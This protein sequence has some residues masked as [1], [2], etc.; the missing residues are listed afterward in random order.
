MIYLYAKN[1]NYSKLANGHVLYGKGGVPNFPVRLANEIFRRCLSYSVKKE[2]ISVYDCCCGG[3]YFATVLGLCNSNII[4][5]IYVS[6][7]DKNMLEIASRNLSLLT[8]QGLYDRQENLKDLYN[9]YKKESH[10]EAI[11]DCEELI[12]NLSC[13]IQYR[14]YEND[15]MDGIAFEHQV[16]IIITDVPYGN[17]CKWKGNK[18]VGLMENLSRVSHKNT[19]AAIVSDKNQKI[20]YNEHWECLEKKKIGKRKFIILKKHQIN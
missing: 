14:I 20:D 9:K 4:S 13:D 8:H 6:D 16:D 17:M 19:I 3:G 2:N 5:E 12:K 10:Y 11:K 7:I 1:E 15:I 18:T